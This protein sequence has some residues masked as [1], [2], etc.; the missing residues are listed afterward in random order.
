MIDTRDLTSY[1]PGYDDYC[2]SKE[3]E[4]NSWDLADVYYDEMKI[5]EEFEEMERKVIDLSTTDMTFDKVTQL[6][7]YVWKDKYLIPQE[8]L[9][10]E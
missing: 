10:G 4:D 1:Y 6:E 5:R 7:N 9:E 3:F 2:E 8:Q